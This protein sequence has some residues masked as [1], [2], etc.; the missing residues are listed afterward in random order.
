MEEPP[1]LIT[2]GH[3]IVVLYLCNEII[4][5]CLQRFVLNCYCFA[6]CAVQHVV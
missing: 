2:T 5:H 1:V 4:V 6:V 3:N